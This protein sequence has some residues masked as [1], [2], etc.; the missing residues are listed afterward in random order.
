MVYSAGAAA[1]LGS[2]SPLRETMFI[3]GS[4]AISRAL[5]T[6]R[7]KILYL[8]VG[9]WN[10]LFQYGV[11]SLCWYLLSPY[12]PPVPILLL[13]YVIGSVNGFL[14]FRFIVFGASG[15]HP[16]LEYLRFQLVYLPLLALNL[17][18]LPLLLRHTNWNAYAIQAAFGAFA[19]VAG[20]LG[21]K[22]FAFHGATCGSSSEHG[23]AEGDGGAPG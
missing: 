14:G 23:Q 15:T 3:M 6:H 5:S 7:E 19:V 16:L 21:N 18:G 20:F 2:A 1:L 22:Y 9:G 11:F 17:V 12:W 13:S 4:A 10:T 8:V